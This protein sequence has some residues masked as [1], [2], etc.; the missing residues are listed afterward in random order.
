MWQSIRNWWANLRSNQQPP[1]S[2]NITPHAVIYTI[3]NNRNWNDLR[4]QNYAGL[5][6][7][8]LLRGDVGTEGRLLAIWRSRPAFQAAAEQFE[9]ELSL[10]DRGPIWEGFYIEARRPD[11]AWWKSWTVSQLWAAIATLFLILGYLEQIRDASG[12]LIGPPAIE[13]AS[14]P[15]TINALIGETFA[16]K[17]VARNTRL[18][19]ECAVEFESQSASPPNGIALDPLSLRVVPAVQPN[20]SAELPITGKALQEGVYELAIAGKATAG[21]IPSHKNFT[22]SLKVNVWRPIALGQRRIKSISAGGKLCEAELELRPGRSFPRGLDVE[23][24]I[25]QMPGVR[26]LGVR[27]PGVEQ[28]TPH[29]ASTQP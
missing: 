8:Q 27:F 6:F 12:W 26:F 23:A 24:Q 20:E 11:S 14:S 18:L 7:V 19:G 25:K 28:F 17:T 9:T 2:E 29:V 1:I 10:V 21:L 16:A 22:S 4:A 3:P 5:Q 15:T 13:V